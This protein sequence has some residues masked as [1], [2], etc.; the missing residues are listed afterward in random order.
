MAHSTQSY[1]DYIH[2]ESPLCKTWAFIIPLKSIYSGMFLFDILIL[3]WS[4]M[5]VLVEYYVYFGFIFILYILDC[6]YAIF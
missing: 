1:S 6:Y 3:I 4:I 2:D 5:Y